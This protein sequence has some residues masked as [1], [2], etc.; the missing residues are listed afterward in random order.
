MDQDEMI[1]LRGIVYML[2]KIW[3]RSEPWI[4]HWKGDGVI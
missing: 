1:V 3:S 2:K 4:S